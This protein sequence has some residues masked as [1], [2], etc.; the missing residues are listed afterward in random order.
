[1]DQNPG[2][3]QGIGSPDEPIVLELDVVG[4]AADCFE[5]CE[6]SADPILGANGIASVAE[7]PD[8]IYSIVLN[9]A[10]APGAFATGLV[11]FWI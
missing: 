6:T 3:R 8:G 5:L 11:S 4:N 2:D 9:H 7:V 10:I 1:M